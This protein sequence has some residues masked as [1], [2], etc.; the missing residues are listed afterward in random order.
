MVQTLI[1]TAA[2]HTNFLS[3]G[4]TTAYFL[5]ILAFIFALI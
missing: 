2:R 4:Y 5:C 3:V 1:S